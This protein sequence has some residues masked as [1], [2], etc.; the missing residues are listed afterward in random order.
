M[1]RILMAVATYLFW[2]W[3]H[4][5]TRSNTAQPAPRHRRSVAH[6]TAAKPVRRSPRRQT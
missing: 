1:R 6:N 4:G 5:R 3:W 2:Q